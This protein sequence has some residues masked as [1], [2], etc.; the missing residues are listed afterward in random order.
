MNHKLL[1]IALAVAALTLGGCKEKKPVEADIITERYVPE[2]P[3]GPIAMP[4]D[5]QTVNVT[6]M[7]K[8]YRIT[9]TRVPVDSMTVSD[10]GGQKYVDN[11]CR[12]TVRRQDGSVF[13]EKTFF[14]STFR[15]YI[16]EPFISRGILAGLRF[17]EVD[18]SKLDFSAV[19]AMPDAL[20]DLFMPLDLGIDSQGGISIKLDDDMG[21]RDYEDEDDNI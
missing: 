10:D 19:V 12:L 9:V 18:G 21:M 7:G 6:W 5:S 14:K 16:K 11:R 13:T 2:R 17:D 20:D 4:T 1:F 8:P 3:Q 15:S